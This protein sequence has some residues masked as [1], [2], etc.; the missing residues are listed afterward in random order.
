MDIPFNSTKNNKIFIGFQGVKNRIK[1]VEELYKF[2]L[3]RKSC[4][5]IFI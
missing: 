1:K 3:H 4:D 5:L 2:F